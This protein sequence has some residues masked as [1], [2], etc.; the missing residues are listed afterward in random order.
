MFLLDTNVI[1]E[2]RKPKPHGAVLAWVK[3]ADNSQLHLAAI[4][5]NIKMF[6]PWSWTPGSGIFKKYGP[7][8][9][10]IYHFKTRYG[11][12]AVVQHAFISDLRRK[13]KAIY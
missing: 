9:R 6:H 11:W 13:S 3:A 1:S 5:L 2:L 8:I 4:T 10:F 12:I 7:L